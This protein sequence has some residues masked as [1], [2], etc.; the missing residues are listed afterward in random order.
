MSDQPRQTDGPPTRTA[1][2]WPGWPYRAARGRNDG[3]SGR[4]P[5]EEESLAPSETV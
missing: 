3:T 4:G 1:A 2:A 5:P